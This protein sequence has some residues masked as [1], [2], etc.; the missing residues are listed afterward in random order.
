[1]MLFEILPQE[2]P[3]QADV[4]G[5]HTSVIRQSLKWPAPAPSWSNDREYLPQSGSRALCILSSLTG[6]PFSWGRLEN[7]I[8]C[9]I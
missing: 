6:T 5:K 1:M 3:L 8:L 2:E 9:P 7:W 4:M